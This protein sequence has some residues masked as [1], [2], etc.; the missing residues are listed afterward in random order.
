MGREEETGGAGLAAAMEE[1]GD[2]WSLLVVEALLEGPQTFGDLESRIGG[3]AASTLSARLKHLGGI[4][5]L[6]A[7]PYSRRPVRY[8]YEL[9]AGG[10]DLAGAL[11]L[12]AG[13]GAARRGGEPA[14]RHA[15]C[16][17]VAQARWWC[18]TCETP[19]DDV[20]DLHHL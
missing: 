16:G 18:P 13:W 11:R 20:T 2:R 15:L 5:L 6:L 14:V 4:G 7:T 10:R 1:I 17:T 8:R 19:A 12:L 9:T 3:I